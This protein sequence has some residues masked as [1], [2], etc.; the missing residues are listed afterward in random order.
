MQTYTR[1]IAAAGTTGNHTHALDKAITARS[2]AAQLDISASGAGGTIDWILEGS[3]DGTNWFAAA[4][5]T[6]ADDT[7]AFDATTETEEG[8]YLKY[9]WQGSD[10][11]TAARFFK[12][13]RVRTLNNTNVTYKVTFSWVEADQLDIAGLRVLSAPGAEEDVLT[14]ISGDWSSAAMTLARALA[15]GN[16]ADGLKIV[17][18]LDPDDDQDA[19]TKKYVDDNIGSPNGGS[20]PVNSALIS[21]ALAP[22]LEAATFGIAISSD[23]RTIYAV[24]SDGHVAIIDALTGATIDTIALDGTVFGICALSPDD[25]WLYVTLSD[26]GSGTAGGIAAI[27]TETRTL[28]ASIPVGETNDPWWVAFSPDSETAYVAMDNANAVGVI[29]VATHTLTDTIDTTGLGTQGVAV[30]PDGTKVY[31]V[32]GSDTNG[33]VSVIED[34]EETHLIDLGASGGYAV[35][36]SPDGTKAYVTLSGANPVVVIDV[37]THAVT[38][39]VVVGAGAQ[40][41]VAAG[42]KVYVAN[43]TDGTMSVVDIETDEVV[44]T[45][46]YSFNDGYQTPSPAQASAAAGLVVMADASNSGIVVVGAVAIGD[47]P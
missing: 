12:Y 2:V 15:G 7:P 13:F 14:V 27:N 4:Y 44:T 36:F 8:S 23:G 5:I 34:G 40:G 20:Q 43:S 33:T 19:A 24:V 6:D 22:A 38:G 45:K 46:V 29:D 3:V 16:D 42:S 32:N 28:V 47:L 11:A 18:L 26:D 39:T 35:C 10:A 37:A 30:S 41:I 31:A 1:T 9:F 25:A 21:L 17:N